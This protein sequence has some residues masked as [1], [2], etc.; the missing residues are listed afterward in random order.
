V[1]DWH[2]RRLEAA[3]KALSRAEPAGGP[4]TQ[5]ELVLRAADSAV[6]GVVPQE[7]YQQLALDNSAW[8]VRALQ[9]EDLLARALEA[10]DAVAAAGDAVPA[11]VRNDAFARAVEVRAMLDAR[12]DPQSDELD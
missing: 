9:D 10:L 6:G 7:E 4:L 12:R 8:R 5:A 1:S 2:R 11:D 3:G